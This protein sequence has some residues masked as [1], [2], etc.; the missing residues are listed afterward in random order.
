MANS[1]GS[2]NW[3]T[4][5]KEA[6]LEP[7]HKKTKTRVAEAQTAI[8]L[9]ALEMWYAGPMEATERSQMDAASHFLGIL[10]QIGTDK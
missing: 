5:Y 6:V 3:R 9:R 2:H 4:L 8:R 1:D 7:D 10:C